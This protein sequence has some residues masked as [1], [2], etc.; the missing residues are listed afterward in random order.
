M[1]KLY[2]ILIAAAVMLAGYSA[3]YAVSGYRTDFINLYG[4]ATSVLNTCELCHIPPGQSNNNLNGYGSDYAA[5]GYSFAAIEPLDSDGDGFTNI[6]EINARTFP[7]NAASRPAAQDTTLPTV[8]GFSIPAVSTGLTVSITTFTAT[9]N[10]GVTGYMVTESSAAPTASAQGWTVAA[11]TS[12]TFATAGAKTLFAW[13][14][15]AAGNVSVSLSASVTISDTTPPTVSAVIPAVNATGVAVN[16]MV[17]ATFSEAMNAATINTTNFTISG[18]TGTVTY[19]ATS[20]TATFTLSSNL[21]SNTA[22][23]V[24]ITTGVRDSAGNAMAAN[25]TWRFTTGAASDTTPPTVSSVSPAAN[26]TGVA[27]NTTVT[28]TFSETMSAATITASTFT[29]SSSSGP[30]AGT[31]SYD[32]LTRTA[33]FLPSSTLLNSITYTAAITTGVKDSANNAMSS[34]YTWSFTII[35]A[36]SDSDGDGVPDNMDAF[37][38]DNRIASPQTPTGTGSVTIDTSSNAGTSLADVGTLSDTDPSVNQA[39]KP[40]G[41]TFMHGL[42][43]FRVMGVPIGGTIQ[44]KLT[45]PDLLPEGSTVYKVNGSTGYY[46]AP[47]AS[48]SGNMVVLTI[49]DGGICDEDGKADGVIVDPVGVGTPAST[50]GGGGSSGVGGGFCFI[51]TAAYGSYLDPHVKV[52]RDFRDNYLLTNAPGRVFVSLYYKASPPIA[53]FISRHDTVKTATRWLLTPVVYVVEYPMGLLLVIAGFGAAMFI[54]RKNY[55]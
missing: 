41:Y 33:T 10:V 4:T 54:Y 55:V 13:A 37:P 24:T 15:D 17:T 26:A 22:Y 30:V 53:E 6:T 3:A 31:V 11:P 14:K 39:N 49:T 38:Y 7:G 20:R 5:N 25:Y 21:S 27:V 19:D 16:T 40:S 1:K 48:I 45:Y 23:T 43:T 2:M 46:A 36:S 9:D 28:A 18:V 47:C 8:T 52:L 35:A 32:P 42:V 34:A 51:A 44:V 29:L 12:Y 50:S